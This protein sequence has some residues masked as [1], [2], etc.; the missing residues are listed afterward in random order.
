M[1]KDSHLKINNNNNVKPIQVHVPFFLIPGWG[2]YPGVEPVP[3][4]GMPP[5]P[6]GGL[7]IPPTAHGP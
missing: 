5:I 2:G 7:G 4:M 3:G 1:K 6:P